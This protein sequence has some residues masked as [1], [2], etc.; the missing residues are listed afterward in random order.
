[1]AVVSLGFRINY[2]TLKNK[3]GQKLI[4]SCNFAIK[5]NLAVDPKNKDMVIERATN[6]IEVCY[7]NE[8]SPIDW[9]AEIE[10]E[11]NYKRKLNDSDAGP[12]S[13]QSRW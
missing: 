13:K 6:N 1:M 10:R 12:S 7:R 5:M 4:D 9:N 11:Q 2:L 3:I 8:I